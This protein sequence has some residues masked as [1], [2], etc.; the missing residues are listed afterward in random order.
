[1]EVSLVSTN[2]LQRYELSYKARTATTMPSVSRFSGSSRKS[3][4][5]I[6]VYQCKWPPDLPQRASK[7]FLIWE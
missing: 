6:A 7:A 1:M 5:I 2:R 4:E 3:S